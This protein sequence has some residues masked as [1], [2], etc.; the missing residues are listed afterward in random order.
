MAV[1]MFQFTF[2]FNWF[3][4]NS[5]DQERCYF[6]E[7]GKIL[8]LL[9][10]ALKFYGVLWLF[11]QRLLTTIAVFQTPPFLDIW[12]SESFSRCFHSRH[13]ASISSILPYTFRNPSI[14]NG[15]HRLRAYLVHSLRKQEFSPWPL[16]L[17]LSLKFKN[18]KPRWIF[19]AQQELSLNPL[20][21]EKKHKN[22]S[23]DSPDFSL[24][25]D[26]AH[27]ISSFDCPILGGAQGQI[28]WGPE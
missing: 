24:C 19:K 13:F 17:S 16:N 8:Y 26:I 22:S 27:M 23:S 25:L 20:W 15:L 10:I 12:R 6:G 1:W 11:T 3:F 28:G 5:I 2:Y 14:I 21:K 4:N 18:P 7:R 9:I